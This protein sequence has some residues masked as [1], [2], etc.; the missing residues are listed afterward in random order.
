[1]KKHLLLFVFLLN[2]SYMD[3]LPVGNP[4]TPNFFPCPYYSLA[5][6]DEDAEYSFLF[7][8]TKLGVGFYGDYV[9]QR[10]LKTSQNRM[11]DYSQIFTNGAYIIINFCQI[12]DFFTT[13]GATKFKFS[14]SLG[15]FNPTNTSP[16]FD[17]LSSTT[18]SWSVGSHVKL[19][20]YHCF[21]LGLTGQYFE[22]HPK[23]EVLFVRANVNSYPDETT[24]RRYS[25]WQ[26]AGGVSY[27]FCESFFPY[28]ALK[29]NR[30]CW[31][32]RDETFNITDTLATI[33][34][35]KNAKRWGFAAGLALEFCARV[36]INVEGR[37]VDENAVNATALF[38]F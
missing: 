19:L 30:V 12:A 17:F 7:D 34:T 31:E 5:P 32:F 4:A 3:A 38:Q 26:V 27:M 9:F 11:V 36:I 24:C 15:P 21:V 16:R 25:E 13:L 28:L 8:N 10:Y 37:F 20:D 6:L 22:T 1:M 18:F 23:P 2:V 29:Y 14:T 33:P 35:L